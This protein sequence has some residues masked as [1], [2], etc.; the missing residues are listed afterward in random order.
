MR[1]G[2]TLSD[3]SS[4]RYGTLEANKRS[5]MLMKI[6]HYLWSR[7]TNSLRVEVEM[8]STFRQTEFFLAICCSQSLFVSSAPSTGGR[9]LR[10]IETIANNELKKYNIIVEFQI[11]RSRLPRIALFVSKL[12]VTGCP[13]GGVPTLF[14]D[15]SILLKVV[16]NAFG[17]IVPR[18]NRTEI[19]WV[20]LPTHAVSRY[21][22]YK[23]KNML[24][25][26]S[27]VLSWKH[28]GIVPCS[29]RV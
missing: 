16:D 17:K 29:V 3:T 7:R 27:R 19:K 20:R 13:R 26:N 21:F 28:L 12:I 6:A 9:S 23:M 5:I 1:S 14:Q 18:V 8:L 15:S 25:A 2:T 4:W 11:Q 24:S 10:N 22:R